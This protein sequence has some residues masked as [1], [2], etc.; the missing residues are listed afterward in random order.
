MINLDIF[1]K[2]QKEETLADLKTDKE[3][4]K[5]I[6]NHEDYEFYKKQLQSELDNLKGQLNNLAYRVK[7]TNEFSLRAVDILA[8]IRTLDNILNYPEQFVEMVAKIERTEAEEKAKKEREK[9]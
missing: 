4:F 5:R 1:K 6:L 9:K 2:K 3:K 8:S 7:D